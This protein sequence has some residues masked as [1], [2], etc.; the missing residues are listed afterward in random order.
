MRSPR[1]VSTGSTYGNG[2]LIKNVALKDIYGQGRG[3][4]KSNSLKGVGAEHPH[5]CPLLAIHNVPR[6]LYKKIFGKL[7]CFLKASS[8]NLMFVLIPP[9]Q[10]SKEKQSSYT[11]PLSSNII[12]GK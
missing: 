10:F 2:Y 7:Y 12:I 11:E 9:W 6:A 8:G 3:G 1:V 5:D 4:V